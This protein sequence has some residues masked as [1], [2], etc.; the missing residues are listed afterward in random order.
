[1]IGVLGGTF[2]PIHH[3]HLRV[4]LE[5]K[6]MIGLD[7]VRFIPLYRAVHRD[8]PI[9][10]G[11]Q[12][13]RMIQAAISD[14]A[15]FVVDDRELI[16]EGESY[17]V[18]TLRSLRKELGE[19]PMCLIIGAD[20]FRFFL[21]W[22]RPLEILDLAHLIVMMRPGYSEV[23]DP[24]LKRLINDRI[25]QDVYMLQ[26]NP[27]GRIYFCPVT[28]LEISATQ[29]RQSIASGHNPRYLLPEGVI[30][31]IQDESIYQAQ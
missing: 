21:Q 28:Q 25:T 1:M 9:A 22:H 4:A 11:K 30:R 17:T 3:G 20:A 5:V 15:Y 2:D 19:E 31:I 6:E 16:R 23:E 26:T 10:S 13:L 8:Q 27:A 24:S 14:Q 18:D 12:R 7:E 29:I